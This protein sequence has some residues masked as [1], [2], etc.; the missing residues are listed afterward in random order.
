[1]RLLLYLISLQFYDV[2][3]IGE[4][5]NKQTAS[6]IGGKRQKPALNL[7]WSNAE[8]AVLSDKLNL[9]NCKMVLKIFYRKRIYKDQYSLSRVYK[10]FC[11]LWKYLMF[12]AV[13]ESLQIIL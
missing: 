7:T 13:W 3:F 1:M 9:L 12:E 10:A 4:E 5:V 8:A 11:V 2:N 6:Y